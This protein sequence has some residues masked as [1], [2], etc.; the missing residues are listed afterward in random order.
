MLVVKGVGLQNPGIAAD[1]ECGP[2]QFRQAGEES[3]A[4][5]CGRCWR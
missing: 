3:A 1:A 2:G 5:A 4:S